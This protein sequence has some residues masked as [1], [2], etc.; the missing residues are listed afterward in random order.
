MKANVGNEIKDIS[1]QMIKQQGMNANILRELSLIGDQSK[2]LFV[3]TLMEIMIS[4]I[5]KRAMFNDS[6]MNLCWDII[7]SQDNQNP[8]QSELWQAIKTQCND[9]I[10][11]GSKRDWYWLKKVLLPST[12]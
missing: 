11:N 7:V 4:I 5:N 2:E 1:Q 3:R 12:V 8:L 6:I 9:I 10:Q